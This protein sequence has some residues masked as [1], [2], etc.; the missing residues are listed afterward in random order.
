M[1]FKKQP[2]EASLKLEGSCGGYNYVSE[3]T[4]GINSKSC[5]VGN[6]TISVV[7]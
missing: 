1:R 3:T 5:H 4:I 6:L 2:N 7:F